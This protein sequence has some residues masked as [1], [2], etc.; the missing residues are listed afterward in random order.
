MYVVVHYAPLLTKLLD[1]A[2]YIF[3]THILLIALSVAEII[4]GFYLI[5]RFKNDAILR[6]RVLGVVIFL[7]FLNSITIPL[8]DLIIKTHLESRTNSLPMISKLQNTDQASYLNKHEP[9]HCDT[10]NT[11]QMK[12]WILYQNDKLSICLFHPATIDTVQAEGMAIDPHF[13]YK[14][15]K[16]NNSMDFYQDGVIFSINTD[17]SLED[18]E[19]IRQAKTGEDVPKAHHA[20]GTVVYKIRNFSVDGN[21]AIEYVYD[22]SLPPNDHELAYV[23]IIAVKVK[24]EIISFQSSAETKEKQLKKNKDFLA[25]LATLSI[26]SR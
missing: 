11:D 3:I 20:G 7:L 22:N 15:T 2:T 4:F 21:P 8:S 25:I 24:G 16:V 10:P 19:N 17:W 26:P 23:H 13:Y 12:D 1:G 18:F 9:L 6:K 5:E 14:N